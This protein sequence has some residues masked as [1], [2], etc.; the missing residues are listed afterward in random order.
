MLLVSERRNFQNITSKMPPGLFRLLL[1]SIVIVHHFSS[2]ALGS[3]AVYL[4][5]C[6]SGYWV[7]V[8]WRRK[9]SKTVKPWQ[10]F[11]VSRYW[12]LAPVFLVSSLAALLVLFLLPKFVIPEIAS[13]HWSPI[14]IAPSIFIIGYQFLEFRPL[15]PAW[16]LDIEMQF[17]LVAPLL[18][19]FVEK[20]RLRAVVV[21]L[22]LAMASLVLFQRESLTTLAPFFVAGIYVEK[23]GALPGRKLAMASL[24]LCVL[25]V[26]VVVLVPN[27]R[28]ILIAGAHRTMSSGITEA[29]N[30]LVGILCLPFAFWTVQKRSNAIDKLAADVSY[31]VYLL[32][33]V[34][35]LII[36]AYFPLLAI[37]PF[38]ERM[39]WT[40][41]AI[42]VTY[43]ISLAV[44][45]YI[46]RP[47]NA[48]RSAF[49]NA[50]IR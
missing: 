22:L 9:Y 10:T 14:L 8:M 37:A 44:V 28:G 32:H 16:S 26:L 31:A 40:G 27:T 18:M 25:L 17:Y 11:V 47:L 42:G 3:A 41:A 15:G 46:D 50:R 1:S 19:W 21:M 49:V 45:L 23:L 29:M 39:A 7:S 2:L 43:L 33:W 30:A 38:A 13:A 24:A 48:G 4:F 34:T 35:I 36:T 6:L 12:R 5:F 20:F